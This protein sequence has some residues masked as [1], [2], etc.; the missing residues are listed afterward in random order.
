MKRATIKDR[1]LE[2][3]EAGPSTSRELSKRLGVSLGTVPAC[4][5]QLRDAGKVRILGTARYGRSRALTL[6]WEKT[7]ASMVAVAEVKD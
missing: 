6:I 2:A 4:M 5:S 3:L 1:I 7:N